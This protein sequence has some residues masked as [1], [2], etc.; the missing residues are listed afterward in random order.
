LIGPTLADPEREAR[1]LP[2]S[3]RVVGVSYAG[4]QRA[5]PAR[6]A[7]RGEGALVS[8]RQG[9]FCSV[10]ADELRGLVRRHENGNRS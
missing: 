5:S 6:P 8:G 3:L 9:P 10:A 7:R 2:R 4:L 1:L